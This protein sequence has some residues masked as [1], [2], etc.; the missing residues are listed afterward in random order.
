MLLRVTFILARVEPHH[1]SEHRVRRCFYGQSII[2]PPLCG[3]EL[4][5]CVYAVRPRGAD[6]FESIRRTLYVAAAIRLLVRTEREAPS[7][8]ACSL[9][10]L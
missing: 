10:P 3:P 7:A 4:L 9:Y 6:D 8:G 5:F 2:R 1:L